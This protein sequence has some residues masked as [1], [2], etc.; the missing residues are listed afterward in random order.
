MDLISISATDVRSTTEDKDLD[1]WDVNHHRKRLKFR[2]KVI[3][4]LR[5]LLRKEN[6]D[7]EFNDR[8]KIL[9][10][11]GRVRTVKLKTQSST[12]IRPFPRA[13]QPEVS[14]NNWKSFQLH[15]VQ[16]TEC[17][18]SPNP[19]STEVNQARGTKYGRIVKKHVKLNLLTTRDA[20]E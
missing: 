14:G 18:K 7:R 4:E 5:N 3:D 20:Y 1:M 11:D 2:S 6:L 17:V 8:D 10:C 19:D 15:G 16:P 12:L 13:L 9:R